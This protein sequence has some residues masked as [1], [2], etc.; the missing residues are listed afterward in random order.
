MLLEIEASP[1]SLNIRMNLP[2]MSESVL[3]VVVLAAGKGTRMN[4]DLPKVLH[5]IH[6]KPMIEYVA[7]TAVSLAGEF[8]YIV[9]GHQADRVREE[10]SRRFHVRYVF[11]KE[12]LGTGDAVKEAL[13]VLDHRIEYVLVMCGDVPLIR[14]RT[15]LDLV[16]AHRENRNSLTVLSAEVEDPQG[17]GRII[18]DRSGRIVCIREQ[19]DANE[20]EKKIRVVNSGIFCFDK[21]FLED[22]IPMITS[23]NRQKEYYLTD[24]IEIAAG[25][26]KKS[27]VVQMEDAREMMGVNTCEQLA[28]MEKL[29]Q[30]ID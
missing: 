19:A 15:L 28:R 9:V 10:V 18:L 29:L 27:G 4:S 13:P 2:T 6:A 11:Q 25:T 16:D 24:L 12:L 22:S 3:G 26:G 23:E 8:V 5:R 17:Y 20:E 30:S 7:E 1:L 21:R 14:K